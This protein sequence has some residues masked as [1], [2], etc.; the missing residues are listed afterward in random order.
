MNVKGKKIF[1]V[2][3][4]TNKEDR[5]NFIK[6]WA[7]FMKN[8][9]DKEWSKQQVMLID[10][11]FYSARQFYSSLERTEDGKRTLRRILNLKK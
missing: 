7:E 3:G 4:K 1:M 9:S 6:F 5:E 11:Q 8:V 10:S 2:P